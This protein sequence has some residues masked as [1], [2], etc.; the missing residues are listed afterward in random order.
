MASAS[1]E[2]RRKRSFPLRRTFAL[3]FLLLTSTTGSRLTAVTPDQDPRA[4]VLDGR[5]VILGRVVDSETGDGIA[6]AVVVLYGPGTTRADQV[7]TTGAGDFVFARVPAGR[8]EIGAV[9]TRHRGTSSRRTIVEL[10]DGQVTSDVRIALEPFSEISGTVVDENG[11]PTPGVTVRL[12]RR[13][14]RGFWQAYMAVKTNDLGEYQF[15]SLWAESYLV[16][17]PS[18]Q[19]SLPESTI[20][21]LTEAASGPADVVADLVE[22][23]RPLGL[24][25]RS[26]LRVAPL[27]WHDLFLLP[28]GAARPPV[29]TAAGQAVY[30]TQFFPG[31]SSPAQ[32]Q[33]LVVRPGDV[34][35]H[36]DFQLRPMIAASVSGRLELEDGTPASLLV[37]NLIPADTGGFDGLPPVAATVSDARGRFS[38]PLV[39]RGDYRLEVLKVPRPPMVDRSVDAEVATG[40]GAVEVRSPVAPRMGRDSLHVGPLL[41]AEQRV[42]VDRDVRDVVAIVRRGAVATGSVVF[43]GTSAPPPGTQYLRAM[44]QFRDAAGRSTPFLPGRLNADLEFATPELPPGRYVVW[45]GPLGSWGVRSIT[46]DG[47]NVADEP[48]DF[49][50]EGV[51]GI[52]VTYSDRLP[53]VTGTVR[54]DR[55]RPVAG[56][57]VLMFPVERRYWTDGG[58]LPRRMKNTRTSTNGSYTIGGVPEGDYYL[59]ATADDP[60][61]YWHTPEMLGNALAHAVKVSLSEGQR[62]A[63]DLTVPLR[64]H[65]GGRR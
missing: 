5:G 18:L 40:S 46:L 15:T 65:A 11:E 59:A 35:S 31:A 10:A 24:S 57:T 38:L 26:T 60:P 13:S 43:D 9:T 30:P 29:A 36:I 45:M 23:L 52:T 61:V 56:G 39:P 12:A 54:D 41:W 33:A 27:Q 63:A 48:F 16:F 51:S 53:T 20:A 44:V 62:A 49:G 1:A 32:A 14:P 55:G 7:R 37:V 34:I 21:A 58:A 22:H 17:V 8:W 6:D 3:L 19:A 28:N 4:P 47:R 64:A 42:V 50:P 2:P 25:D